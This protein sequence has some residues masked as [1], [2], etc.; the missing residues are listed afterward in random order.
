MTITDAAPALDLAPRTTSLDPSA[1]A[2]P[3]GR[4]EQWRFAPMDRL[5]W[6]LADNPDAGSVRGSGH[7]L[8]S[9][10]PM[11]EAHLGNWVPTD[12]PS[13]IARRGAR[14]AVIVDIP[15]DTV[16]DEPIQVVLQADR[17]LAYQHVE[18]RAGAFSRASV[19]VIHP[20]AGRISGALAVEVGDGASLQVVAIVDGSIVDG[21]FV[22]E[23][24]SAATTGTGSMSHVGCWPAILGR[25]ASYT[26]C[27]V[28][29]GGHAVR[30]LPSVHYRGPGGSAELLGV[31]LADGDEYVEHRIFVEHDQPRCSSNV[32]Y[33]GALSG[34]HAHSV[35][36]GDVVVRREAVGIN[37]YEVNRN[38]LLNDGPRA[39]SVPNL[40]LETGDVEGAGHASATGRFD[41]QQLFYL[42]SRGIPEEVARQLVVRGFFADVLGRLGLPELQ[43]DIVGRI[44]ARLGLDSDG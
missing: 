38:L 16:I 24:A 34:D 13:A 3:T 5:R 39:D 18:I 42:M 31:F 12:L 27:M 35:W 7:R 19:I 26:G 36:I 9:N 15:P 20:Q 11:S 43:S 14:N 2:T 37:T 6:A 23:S 30:I 4:E 10:Q 41:E 29:L 32:V 22:G 33:K 28:T 17:P 21:S 40:E 1:F 8:V 25:D 44:S